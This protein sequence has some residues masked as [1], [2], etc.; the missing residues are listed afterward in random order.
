MQNSRI[1]RSS[2]LG[3]HPRLESTVK[4]HLKT[5][6]RQPLRGFSHAA[7]ESLGDLANRDIVLDAG[8]G[9]GHSTALL[10]QQFPDSLVIGVDRSAARLGSASKL[11]EN[12]VL[13]RADLADFWRLARAAGWRLKRHY[14]LYPNPWPKPGH[15]KRRWHAHP[16]WPDLLVLGGGLELRTNF[17]IYAREFVDALD[18][19]GCQAHFRV[20]SLGGEKAISPFEQ[21]YL[22]S[23]H[24]LFQVC[25][26]LH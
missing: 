6:W 23:G 8:C 24:D 18:L 2:Q 12:A 11:P 20:L 25:A 16:V 22:Q 14:L 3:P 7:F 26:D 4:R 10:A 5:L 9:N 17:E 1:P 19:A 13:L 21:K 15:L